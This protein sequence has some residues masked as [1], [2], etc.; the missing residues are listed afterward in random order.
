M[1]NFDDLSDV[2]IEQMSREER[3]R[4]LEQQLS[5]QD[6]ALLDGIAYGVAKLLNT[7]INQLAAEA[8]AYRSVHVGAVPVG[9]QLAH[10]DHLVGLHETYWAA[11]AQQSPTHE[12][13]E[14]LRHQWDPWITRWYTTR[15]YFDTDEGV[16][17]FAA[18]LGHL[19]DL[20]PEDLRGV[21]VHEAAAGLH[22]LRDY[23]VSR[24][25]PTPELDGTKV[26]GAEL[27]AYNISPSGG[28]NMSLE[29]FRTHAIHAVTHASQH[30]P[31]PA[32]GYLRIGV[33]QKIY[34]FPSDHD[35]VAWFDQ[36]EQ[37]DTGFDYAAV[38]D[39]AN[40]HAPIAEAL[41]ASVPIAGCEPGDEAQVGHWFLPLALGVPAG[42]LGGYF[43]RQWQE[44]HPGKYIPWVSG[45]GDQIRAQASHAAK[46]AFSGESVPYL[47]VVVENNSSS[48]YKTF[49]SLDAASDWLAAGA[50]LPYVKAHLY[51]AI[52]DATDPTWPAP[53]SERSG[54]SAHTGAEYSPA[55]AH[56]EAARPAPISD[57][58]RRR[59]WPLTK[60]LIKS[61]MREA[62]DAYRQAPSASYLW[63]LEPWGQSVIIPFS[64]AADALDAMRDRIHTEH[65]ALAV[66]DRGS[67]HWP[68]PVNWTRND[69][70]AY[71]NVIAQQA[72]KPANYGYTAVSGEPW[73][74]VV[75]SEPWYSIIGSEPWY[76][77]I[78]RDPQTIIGDAIQDVR[79][80]A[81]SL[82]SQKPG[83]AVGVVHSADGLWH[84]LAFRSLD[85]ADDWFGTAIRDKA[86]F[87]Y[88]AYFDKDASG[89]AFLENEEI[90][91][92]RAPS[93]PGSGI[94]RGV[95]T[96]Y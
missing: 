56:V 89:T 70:P 23:A 21:L 88:A 41:G 78:G 54:H 52:Y 8:A 76:T 18:H 16:V 20:S 24:G 91:G 93:A 30:S 26:S 22:R 96:T 43:Y 37:T 6:L 13:R 45:E 42:A 28:P 33:H 86:A 66:F 61:A 11:L 35:A 73:V 31:S 3:R 55:Y 85:D 79:I 12:V 44:G 92:L 39:A 60:A 84:T 69:D 48:T 87:T 49:P 63:S 34:L 68:N 80:R 71:A 32:Y 4:I 14:F 51:A 72:A 38:F 64:S 9:E 2:E 58:E 53:I 67:S 5:P 36:R 40:L 25:I 94:Q 95:A 47:G 82:A 75:G 74:S 50:P 1:T 90:G 83:R 59:A 29:H 19:R 17:A 81:K 7:P 65:V 27:P 10:F 57:I 15:P 77:I 46:M 62:L